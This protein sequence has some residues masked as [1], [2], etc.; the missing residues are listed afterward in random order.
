MERREEPG[1]GG[2][3]CEIR[4]LGYIAS[5]C[6][7]WFCIPSLPPVLCIPSLLMLRRIHTSASVLRLSPLPS[8]AVKEVRNSVQK[9]MKTC[10]LCSLSQTQHTCLSPVESSLPV[11]RHLVRKRQEREK[12][13][14]RDVIKR[15]EGGRAK[16]CLIGRSRKSRTEGEEEEQDLEKRKKET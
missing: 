1:K 3:G 10:Y 6:H 16:R 8:S 15:G 2:G 14:N 13:R 5:E 9:R 11:L 7:L 12:E 4:V